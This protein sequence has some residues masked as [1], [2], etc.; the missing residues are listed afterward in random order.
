MGSKAN[1]LRTLMRDEG[2]EGDVNGFLGKCVT[3]SVVPGICKHCGE[4][5]SVEPDQEQGWCDSCDKGS[6]RS[7]LILAGII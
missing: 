4:T 2:Y 1:D 3:D 6:V 7:A 5:A